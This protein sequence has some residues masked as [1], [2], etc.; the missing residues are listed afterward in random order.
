[1]IGIYGGTFNPIHIAHLRAAEEVRA[2][3]GLEKMLFVPNA[4][5]PHKTEQREDI[6]PAD[7]RLTWTRLAVKDHPFFEVDALEINRPGESYLVD[8]LRAL[9]N[10]Y[11][12]QRLVFVVGQDAFAEMGSWRAPR[13]IFGLVDIA[14]TTRPPVLEAALQ[15]WFPDCVRKDFEIDH[16]KQKARHR[17]RE[18]EVK[19]VAVTPM[20]ISSSE[21]RQAIRSGHSIEQWVPE[22]IQKPILKSGFYQQGPCEPTNRTQSTNHEN[23]TQAKN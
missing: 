7:L 18:T 15:A 20:D 16:L 3:L 11:R 21:I 9:K 14:V 4:R 12:D 5:P 1:M 23:E 17:T 2:R 13:E 10:Q 22:A 19:L 8:T 6:A